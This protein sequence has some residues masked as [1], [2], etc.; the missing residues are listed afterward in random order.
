MSYKQFLNVFSHSV[1]LNELLLTMDREIMR[2]F[3]HLYCYILLLLF[4]PC[5][6]A[7]QLALQGPV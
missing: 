3:F 5:A 7:T 6:E 2:I 1:E 4:A